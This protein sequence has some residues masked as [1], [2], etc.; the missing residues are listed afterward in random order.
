M[1]DDGKDEEKKE[2]SRPYVMAKELFAVSLAVASIISAVVAFIRLSAASTDIDGIVTNWSKDPVSAIKFDNSGSCGTGYSAFPIMEW[3]GGTGLGCGCQ[4]GAQYKLDDGTFKTASSSTAAC[5]TNQTT[6]TQYTCAQQDSMNEMDLM[7]WDGQQICYKTSFDNAFDTPYPD[8]DTGA[9]PSGY[10]NCNNGGTYDNTGAI[11]VA[12]SFGSTACPL[13]WIGSDDTIT[14]FTGAST[15]DFTTDTTPES[16]DAPTIRTATATT[17]M[18]GSTYY[19]YQQ[20][21]STTVSS[22]VGVDNDWLPLPI[23]EWSVDWMQN[24]DEMYGPCYGQGQTNFVSSLFTASSDQ[25]EYGGEASMSSTGEITPDRPSSCSKIDKR[26][27]ALEFYDED[28]L[29]EYNAGYNIDPSFSGPCES[30]PTTNYNYLSTGSCTAGTGTTC[31][32]SNKGGSSTVP[33]STACTACGSDSLCRAAYC[34]STCGQYQAYA[35]KSTNIGL[36]MRTQI[37]WKQ[38]C[39]YSYTDVKKINGPLQSA[40]AAQTALLVINLIV[41]VILIMFGIYIMKLTYDNWDTDK[42]EYSHLEDHVKPWAEFFGNWIKV[43]VIIAT[44]VLTIAVMDFF[45]DVA[46]EE[47]SDETTN[48]TFEYL[49]E[50]LPEVVSSNSAVLAMDIIMLVAPYLWGWIKHCLGWDKKDE[51]TDE[52][53][54]ISNVEM[55]EILDG[56]VAPS[57]SGSYGDDEDASPSRTDNLTEEEHAVGGPGNRTAALMG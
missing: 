51:E 41:N 34:Q 33:G 44:L 10:H 4:S 52:D 20:Y 49:A 54:E 57:T 42:H 13:T 2:S 56:K 27:R 14:Q 9:C 43:P 11:C 24:G 6:V 25:D 18:R 22:K 15:S 12:D 29:F 1:S 21:G 26:W 53:K 45:V 7:T 48:Y 55:G 40:I 38:S 36:M 47:C 16:P 32:G 39:S 17:T 19:I 35:G 5:L 46:K 28:G 3:P 8:E 31:V 30:S 23:V 50:K 37:L